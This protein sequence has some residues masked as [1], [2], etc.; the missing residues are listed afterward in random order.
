MKVLPCPRVLNLSD[1]EHPEI[2]SD[3]TRRP[4]PGCL[5]TV[6]QTL[7]SPGFPG[8]VAA[9]KEAGYVANNLFCDYTVVNGSVGYHTDD[10]GLIAICMVDRCSAFKNPN[11]YPCVGELITPNGS[12]ELAP[13]DILIFDSSELHAWIS[14]DYSLLATVTIKPI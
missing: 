14:G 9:L 3:E 10:L 2:F 8:F 11:G 6:T 4:M 5:K 1:F 13:S 7:E 12:Y